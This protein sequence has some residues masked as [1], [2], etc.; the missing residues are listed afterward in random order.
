MMH[1]GGC[2]TLLGC[3][4]WSEVVTTLLVL[5]IAAAGVRLHF[6]NVGKTEG[7]DPAGPY[8]SRH[9]RLHLKAANDGSV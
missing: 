2:Q 1:A 7:L 4:T 3:Q 8:L 5:G 9:N 6:I